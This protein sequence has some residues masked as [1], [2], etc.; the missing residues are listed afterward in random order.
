MMIRSRALRCLLFFLSQSALGAG[1]VTLDTGFGAG[2]LVLPPFSGQPSIES[3][4]HGRCVTVQ[5]D[6]KILLAG[7]SLAGGGR[8]IAVLRFLPDGQLDA[9]F[10][11]AGVAL[12]DSPNG[13][14]QASALQLLENGRILVAGRTFAGG[15]SDMLLLRL[16]ADGAPDTGFGNGG[17]VQADFDGADDSAQALTIDQLGRVIAAGTASLA[18]TRSAAV[19][20]CLAEGTPDPAFGTSGRATLAITGAAAN[21]GRDL[22]IQ[23]GG[24]IVVGG[25]ARITTNERFALFAFTSAGAPDTTFGDNGHVLTA[26]GSGSNIQSQGQSLIELAGGQLLLA[27]YGTASGTPRAALARYSTTGVL[28]TGFGTAGMVLTAAGSGETRA[29]G[30]VQ[31]ANGDLLVSASLTDAN[32]RFVALRYNTGGSLDSGFGTG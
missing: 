11:N 24:R 14:D 25:H 26:V 10:G 2:G 28:D 21:E 8:R 22:V 17:R 4:G 6:G 31:L 7:H 29:T 20:C 30:V 12:L 13:D 18:G 1:E 19:L 27:G 23:T 32:M 16:T 3:A 15:T 9:T 5:D